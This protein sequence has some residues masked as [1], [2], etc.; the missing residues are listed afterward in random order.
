MSSH[1]PE[2]TGTHHID[3]EWKVEGDRKGRVVLNTPHNKMLLLPTTLIKKLYNPKHKESDAR[4]P[5]SQNH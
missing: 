4:G 1:T 2:K 5:V 3:K